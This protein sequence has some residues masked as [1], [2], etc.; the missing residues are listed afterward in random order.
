M[1]S[2]RGKSSA[3]Q[4]EKK[5]CWQAL[6]GTRNTWEPRRELCAGYRKQLMTKAGGSLDNDTGAPRKP[7]TVLCKSS[8]KKAS[9]RSWSRLRIPLCTKGIPDCTAFTWILLWQ[10]GKYSW[11][12]KILGRLWNTVENPYVC[13]GTYTCK[14]LLM[15]QFSVWGVKLSTRNEFLVSPSCLKFIFKVICT[16]NSF[17]EIP[18]H[19][20]HSLKMRVYRSTEEKYL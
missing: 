16:A 20:L 13:W 9:Y 19:F 3:L 6:S 14:N 2:S 18:P 15:L 12:R 1:A 4:K 5:I 8:Q 7:P 11:L 10:R 17:S